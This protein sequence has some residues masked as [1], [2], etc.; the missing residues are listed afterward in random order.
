M[1]IKRH[2][3]AMRSSLI[4]I[5]VMTF[6]LV[7]FYSGRCVTRM[8][9]YQ[10]DKRT[11][12]IAIV[13]ILGNGTSRAKYKTAM[14]SVLCYAL[15]NNYT[16]ILTKSTEYAELCN[17][18]EFLF[19]R[20]CIVANILQ[21]NNF[22]WILVIDSDTG[23]VNEKVRIEKYIRDEADIMFYDRFFNFEIMAGTY[24]VKKSDYA[25]KFLHG[26]ADYEK[27]LP[28]NFHGLDNGAIHMYM[29]EQLAPNATLIPTCW[30]LWRNTTNFETLTRY[31]L[32]CREILKNSTAGNVVIYGKGEGWARDAWL[33]NSHW[34]PDRDFMFHALKEEHKKKFSAEEKEK[35]DGPPYWPWISTLRTPL[36]TEECR[37]GEFHWDHEPDL[38]SSAKQ[39]NDHMDKRRKEVDD[40]Y[41]SKLIYIQ[42]GHH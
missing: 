22:E 36:D 10:Y 13:S 14:D 35:L 30:E 28:K 12:N 7:I 31:T 4:V 6:G 5:V 17:H 29:V 33:T 25:I 1:M 32:C 18:Q 9:I 26:W 40:E 8:V 38:I 24:L 21:Q 16:F 42:P 41:R 37:M 20:H 19:Q 27:R 39:L 11:T 23:V 34:S 15:Q 3:L 2:I